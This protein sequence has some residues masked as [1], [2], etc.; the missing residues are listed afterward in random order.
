M[1]GLSAG[2]HYTWSKFIDTISEVFNPSS[3]EVAAA[4]DPFDVENDEAV[5]A[6]DRPHRFTANVVWK[7]PLRAIRTGAAGKLLGG[8]H[9]SG[10]M[11]FQS[12]APFT[13][14][15]GVDV[16]NVLAR[17]LVGNAIRPTSTPIWKFI[18]CR[19]KSSPGGWCGP[20]Q[21]ARSPPPVHRVGNVGR[22]TLRADGIGNLDIGFIKNT[23]LAGAPHPGPHRDVQRHEHAQLRH[24][25]RPHQ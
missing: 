13:V 25:R 16:A 8:W 18:R 4:Q 20:L 7:L 6:Y 17:S 12:G 19:S 9:V 3:G 10:L 21:P 22:N 24:S 15:N 2:A 11:T 5:S 14:L 1:E 23:R